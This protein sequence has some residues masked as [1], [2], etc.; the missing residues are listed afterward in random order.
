[1]TCYQILSVSSLSS[2]KSQIKGLHEIET[3]Y[4]AWFGDSGFNK[5]QKT[6]QAGVDLKMLRFSLVMG[7]IGKVGLSSLAL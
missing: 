5:R 4:I 3:S 6:E 7:R 2:F 1:M